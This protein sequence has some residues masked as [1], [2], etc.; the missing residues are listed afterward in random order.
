MSFI[1]EFS[2]TANVSDSLTEFPLV[3]SEETNDRKRPTME[4]RRD[5]ERFYQNAEIRFPALE[6]GHA[7]KNRRTGRHRQYTLA[8]TFRLKRRAPIPSCIRREVG[9][10]LLLP[11]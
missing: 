7:E 10:Y 11:D 8:V 9:G 5:Q 3:A 6:N 1:V 2:C 4:T